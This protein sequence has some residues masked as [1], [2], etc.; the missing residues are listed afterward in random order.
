MR[1]QH[2]SNGGIRKPN[3]GINFVVLRLEYNID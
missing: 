3:P 1:V 2:I